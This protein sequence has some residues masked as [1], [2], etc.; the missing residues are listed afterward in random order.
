MKI[1]RF[2]ATSTIA[3]ATCC[4]FAPPQAAGD[5]FVVVCPDGYEWVPAMALPPDQQDRDKNGNGI[6]CAKGPQ[7]SNE[8]FNAK[9]EKGIQYVD[10]II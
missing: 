10:D 7:G 4:A 6:V 8:H 1:R 2:A 3:V 5:T 9:D